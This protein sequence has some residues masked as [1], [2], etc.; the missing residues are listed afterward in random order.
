ME[1]QP[2][3]H[4]L[5]KRLSCLSSCTGTLLQQKPFPPV[6]FCR[7]QCTFVVAEYFRCW[8]QYEYQ[9]TFHAFP[10]TT[11]KRKRPALRVIFIANFPNV[12]NHT[13]IFYCIALLVFHKFLYRTYRNGLDQVPQSW[14]ILGPSKNS[15]RVSSIPFCREFAF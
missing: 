2:W 6:S 10:W 7:L 13:E 1:Y 12:T 5:H 3:H 8:S 4:N 11:R 14:E 15:S 9:S